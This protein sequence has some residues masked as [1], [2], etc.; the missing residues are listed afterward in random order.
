MKYELR[1]LTIDDA[2]DLAD[3]ANNLNVS[4]SLCNIF[5]QPYLLQDAMGYIAY[6]TNNDNEMIFDIAIDNKVCGR[7][8][9]R[10]R[11]DIDSK[12]CDWNIGWA[13]NIVVRVL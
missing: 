1:K 3:A 10:W 2:K 4:K 7:I 5:S 6:V 13:K 9:T 8:S 12:S 11:S